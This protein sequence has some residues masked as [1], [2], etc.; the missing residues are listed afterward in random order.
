MTLCTTGFIDRSP[1]DPSPSL[2]P[3]PQL[4]AHLADLEMHPVLYMVPW[5]ETMFAAILPLPALVRAWDTILGC[6]RAIVPMV[7]GAF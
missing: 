1:I 4:A 5:L 6:E 2:P 7:A 3:R